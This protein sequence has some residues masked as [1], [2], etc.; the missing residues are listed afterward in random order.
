MPRKKKLPID[1][2]ERRQ[3]LIELLDSIAKSETTPARYRIEAIKQLNELLSQAEEIKQAEKAKLEKSAISHNQSVSDRRREEFETR[4][5]HQKRLSDLEWELR[6]RTELTRLLKKRGFTKSLDGLTKEQ[7]EAKQRNL[8]GMVYP[9]K[10][11]PD[12]DSELNT[13]YENF[14]D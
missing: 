3:E 2:G 1:Y 8:W 10:P 12:K 13:W 14:L 9:D 7:K 11:F 4:F 6:E 5:F